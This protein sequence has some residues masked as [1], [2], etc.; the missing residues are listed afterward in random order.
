MIRE[1]QK[2]GQN[3]ANVEKSMHINKAEQGPTETLSTKYF[4]NILV[5]SYQKGGGR[6]EDGELNSMQG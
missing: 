2:K 4:A 3:E 1:H 6:R 5:K